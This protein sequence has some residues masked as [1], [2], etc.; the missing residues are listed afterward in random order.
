MRRAGGEGRDGEVA[1]AADSTLLAARRL[2]LRGRSGGAG[3]DGGGRLV[4]KPAFLNLEDLAFGEGARPASGAVRLVIRGGEVS[5]ASERAKQESGAPLFHPLRRRESGSSSTPC[6]PNGSSLAG[7]RSPRRPGLAEAMEMV[8]YSTTAWTPCAR[9][10]SIHIIHGSISPSS[11]LSSPSPRI[12][13]ST[14]FA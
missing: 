10:T 1:L 6:S 4:L 3:E 14:P 8:S 5:S 7:R 2:A 11:S 13:S 12:P 9:L